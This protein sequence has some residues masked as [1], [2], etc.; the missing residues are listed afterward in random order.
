MQGMLR[1][2]GPTLVLATALASF[3]ALDRT[4]LHWYA[5]EAGGSVMRAIVSPAAE[6]SASAPA[7][8]FGEF[9][10]QALAVEWISQTFVYP[11][12]WDCAAPRLNE[13]QTRWTTICT[14][15]GEYG[16]QQYGVVAVSVDAL[17]GH[18]GQLA[19]S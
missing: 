10:V 4:T 14:A 1:W 7:T 6:P 17:T 3:M 12:G 8:R 18:A 5:P 11:E 19:R 9:E 15:R 16:H 2:L 13:A